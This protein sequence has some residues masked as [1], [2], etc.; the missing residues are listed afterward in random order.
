MAINRVASQNYHLY[1]CLPFI[2]LPHESMIEFGPCHL[3]A[4]FEI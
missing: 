1:A 2:E 4:R 3:L